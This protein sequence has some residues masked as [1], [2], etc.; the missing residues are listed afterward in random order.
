M[1]LLDTDVLIDVLRRKQVALDW[2]ESLKDEEV[3]VSG[4]TVMELIQ[5]CRN[6]SDQGYV[7]G[8]LVRYIVAWPTAE[9]CQ[10]ALKVFSDHRLSHG[11]G[12]LDAFIGQTAVQLGIALATFNQKHYSVIPDLRT[13]QPYPR[14]LLAQE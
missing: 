1:I 3:L 2:L 11:I 14:V 9:S 6:K 4:F 8:T 5:G 7:E 12:A 13:V 10:K